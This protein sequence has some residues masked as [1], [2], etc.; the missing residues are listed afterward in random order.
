MLSANVPFPLCRFVSDLLDS[1]QGGMLGRSEH[2]FSSF[3]EVISD[4]KQMMDNP[5][6]FLHDS[7]PDRW[8]LS[9]GDKLYGREQ[10]T[11]AFMNAAERMT[12]VMD[13][14]IFG[15]LVKV[16]GKRR[17]VI[18]VSGHS[19]S[20]KSRLVTSGGSSLEKRGWR[21]LRCKFDRT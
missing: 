2:S 5:E 19:G 4:L 18:M 16:I 10:D 17:E 6:K 12:T 1:E 20:G 13:D 15:G 14:P 11:R 21:F 8:K 9:F 7:S 3:K